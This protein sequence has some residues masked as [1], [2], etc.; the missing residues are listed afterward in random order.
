M[1]EGIPVDIPKQIQRGLNE[2]I[3]RMHSEKKSGSNLRRKPGE[4]IPKNPAVLIE[5]S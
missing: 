4:V 2:G 3:L 1:A 5:I